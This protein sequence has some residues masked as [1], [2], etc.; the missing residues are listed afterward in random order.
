LDHALI[1]LLAASSCLLSL[2]GA[3]HALLNKRDSRSALVWMSLNLSLPLIGPFFYW[4]MGINRISRRARSW[5]ES[6]RRL[7][8]ADI[9][10]FEDQ[11]GVAPRL[12]D[13]AAHLHDLHILADRVVMSR[14]REGNRISPLVDGEEAYPAMLVAIRRAQESINLSSYIFDADGIGSAFV[15]HL[16]EAAE[17]G[18]EVRVMIDALGEKY[19]RISPHK[20]FRGTR[21]R[22]EHY[23]PLRHGA[24]INLRNHRKLLI[25]DGR[26]AFSGGMNISNRHLTAVTPTA[27]AVRDMHFCVQGPVVAD[28]QRAFMEDWYF[29]TGE[30]L[31]NPLFFPVIEQ[32]GN[33]LIR[34]VSDGPDKDFRKL[35]QIITGALSCAKKQVSIMTPY[36]I[37]DRPLTSALI[38]TALRGVNVRIVLPG[39]N[40]LPF[41][42]W[43]SRAQLWELLANG[44][45]VYYQP[46]PFVHTK[47]MLVD[48]IWALVGSANL[49]ARSLRLNFELNM[50]VFDTGFASAVNR[51]FSQAFS[52]AREI[53]L[54]ELEQRTLPCKLRDNFARLFT[55]YL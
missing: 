55:P 40:N 1:A 47:L 5:Q 45:R 38:T 15:A 3:G 35:E 51:H 13:A 30:R 8:G 36:F 9:Y 22:F 19:S 37:P 49:D 50:S 29:V 25:I 20:A 39:L 32:C 7:S 14:L 17:R 18:V 54:Q 23:L 26:E 44:I 52:A 10:P 43:A 42:H 16:I 21:V 24:Y 11:Q 34:C 31:D 4:C 27:T 6:G 33:A 41:V 48:E 53:S 28:L 46:A 2:A 12:P